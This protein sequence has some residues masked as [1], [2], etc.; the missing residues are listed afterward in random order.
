MTDKDLIIAFIEW[1]T[2]KNSPYAIMYGDEKRFCTN[3]EELTIEEVYSIYLKEK[4]EQKQ[5]IIDIMNS[6]EETGLYDS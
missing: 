4:E 5:N 3:N 6:D 1:L 2:R